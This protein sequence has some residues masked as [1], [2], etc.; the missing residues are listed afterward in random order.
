MANAGK[1]EKA[2]AKEQQKSP[3]TENVAKKWVGESNDIDGGN[4]HKGEHA[5]L[6]EVTK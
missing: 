4:N 6:S 3:E 1:D 5:F 2:K